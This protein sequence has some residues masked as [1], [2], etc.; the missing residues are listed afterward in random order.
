MQISND[1][2]QVIAGSKGE[3]AKVSFS[4]N[5]SLVSM[6]SPASEFSNIVLK[7]NR[8]NLPVLVLKSS[9]DKMNVSL[10]CSKVILG[11]EGGIG[12]QSP[13]C[14]ALFQE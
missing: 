9:K 13:I 5:V 2:A 8:D 11:G 7:G 14:N 6:E 10:V 3:L 1:I 4:A 12:D